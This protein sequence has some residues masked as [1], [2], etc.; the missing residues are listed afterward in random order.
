MKAPTDDPNES[1]S[2]VN[3][4]GADECEEEFALAAEASDLDSV[5]DA[6]PEDG[7]DDTIKSGASA[8]L[9]SSRD[10]V[11]ATVSV[12][13][14]RRV[15]ATRLLVW[16]LF[17]VIFGLFPL[18]A[19]GF[20]DAMA[21]HGVKIHKVL[22]SGELFV[23]S[24]VISSGA[25]GELLAAAYRGQRNLTV[26]LSGFG[27]FALFTANT[28]GYMLVGSSTPNMVVLVSGVLFVPTLLTSGI[29]IGTAAGR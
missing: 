21:G 25:M 23:V 20:S 13:S 8:S 18:V 27:T 14:R 3:Q 16:T 2:D 29:S 1:R 5:T 26:L 6:L 28:M 22:S 10:G 19:V 15:V 7:D 11:L 12:E 4:K 24:A 17:G 9:A